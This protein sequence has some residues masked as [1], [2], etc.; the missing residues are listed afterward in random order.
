MKCLL[1]IIFCACSCRAQIN[2]LTGN[3]GNERTNANLQEA[4]LTPS[5]VTPDNFGK[6][7]TYSVDGQVYAQPLYVS[8]V[9]IPGIGSVNVLYIAT[10]HNT[11]YAFNAD[12]T[13]P[14]SVLWQSNLGQ[15]VPPLSLFSGYSDIA[16]EIGALSTGA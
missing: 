5:T 13:K 1:L 16:N 15:P 14:N 7:G 6:L 3:G 2:M 11:I 12:S 8:G 9:M 10:M 4:K